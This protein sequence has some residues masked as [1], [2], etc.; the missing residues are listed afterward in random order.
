MYASINKQLTTFRILYL[1]YS[2]E[3]VKISFLISNISAGNIALCRGQRFVC[4]LGVE[5]ACH[6]VY[7]AKYVLYSC[8]TTVT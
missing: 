7:P 3:R 1:G 5:R 4:E 6:V 8:M 2:R